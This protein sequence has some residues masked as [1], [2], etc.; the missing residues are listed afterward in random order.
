MPGLFSRIIAGELP[1][2]F[3]WRDECCV[4]FLSIA[5]LKDGHTLVVPRMEVDHWI[6]LDPGAFTH[7][8]TVSQVIGRA[9]H[10]AYAP[11][12]VALILAGLEVPHVHI[13]LVPFDAMSELNFQRAQQNVPAE[14]L[15]VE[16][17]RIRRTLA[18][19]GQ[20]EHAVA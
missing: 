14:R 15:A 20:A 2:H 4:A 17:E 16:A 3:V 13:H 11:A 9:L 7:L 5:P 6:D 8:G 19:Q 1:G 12:K 18:G 10:A